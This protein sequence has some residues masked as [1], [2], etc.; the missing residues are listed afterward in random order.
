MRTTY[1]RIKGG[2]RVLFVEETPG[3]GRT[4]TRQWSPEHRAA[5]NKSKANRGAVITPLGRFETL[6][7][8][9]RAHN[10]SGPGIK[11]RI[12]RKMPGFSFENDVE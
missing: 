9:G 11:D 8:A 3:Q 6:V 12:R 7:E 1:K 10:M 2:W 5:I 4:P